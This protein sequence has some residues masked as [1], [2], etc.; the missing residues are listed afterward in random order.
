[1]KAPI[2]FPSEH[3]VL[4]YHKYLKEVSPGVF[5][6]AR[7]ED[8][9]CKFFEQGRCSV[10]SERPYECRIYPY[11][12]EWTGFKVVP[13]LHDGCPDPDRDTYPLP[14]VPDH[15]ANL[16]PEWWLAFDNLPT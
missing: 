10:Y 15:I 8:G 9:T 14:E 12:L 7:K 11:I 16:P 13:V 4:D 1:M 6:L 3:S 2:I 5:R